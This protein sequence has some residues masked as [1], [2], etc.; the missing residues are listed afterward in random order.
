MLRGL[1]N[2]LAGLIC[3]YGASLPVFPTV[4]PSAPRTRPTPRQKPLRVQCQNTCRSYSLHCLLFISLHSTYSSTSPYFP[5][6]LFF[7]NLFI[8]SPSQFIFLQPTKTS[9]FAGYL[10]VHSFSPFYT[11]TYFGE[12]LGIHLLPIYF[13][14]ISE[15]LSNSF[16][17]PNLF[18]NTYLVF[19]FLPSL[20][21]ILW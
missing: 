9:L 7:S 2:L 1:P 15:I 8:F 14:F 21:N 16:P 11:K 19:N 20:Q 10:P 18:L 12:G 4:V 5:Y 3:P 6:T 13:I 17:I